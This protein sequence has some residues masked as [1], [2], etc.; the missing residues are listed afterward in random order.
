[1]EDIFCVGE[2]ITFMAA[3]LEHQIVDAVMVI[4]SIELVASLTLV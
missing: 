1:M 2:V 3:G 4:I